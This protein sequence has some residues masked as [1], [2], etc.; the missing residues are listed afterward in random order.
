MTEAPHLLVEERENILI[1]TFNRPDKL[2]A[3]TVAM[4][5]GLGAEVERFRDTP[6]LK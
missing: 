5:R 3:L 6:E 1:V 4:V 2:N